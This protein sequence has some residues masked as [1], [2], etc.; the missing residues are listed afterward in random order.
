MSACHGATKMPSK[1][2]PHRAAFARGPLVAGHELLEVLHALELGPELPVNALRVLK[3]A[4]AAALVPYGASALH[5]WLSMPALPLGAA[6]TAEAWASQGLAKAHL[7]AQP[8]QS[9]LQPEW[10]AS[11]LTTSVTK[12]CH[13]ENPRHDASCSLKSVSS[14]LSLCSAGLE[15]VPGT[16][17]VQPKDWQRRSRLPSCCR[18]R[19]AGISPD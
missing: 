6:C 16:A 5:S 7:K 9:Q 2:V 18:T 19:R 17:G 14:R 13:L 11:M 8:A 15:I 4:A 12:Y 3:K 10:S 1:K